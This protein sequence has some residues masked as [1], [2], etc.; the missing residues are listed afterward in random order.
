MSPSLKDLTAKEVA[1]NKRREQRLQTSI[2]QLDAQLNTW[3]KNWAS[4]RVFVK[5]WWPVAVA[6]FGIVMGLIY[7]GMWWVNNVQSKADVEKVEQRL[8]KR[9][10][11]LVRVRK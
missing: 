2:S 1:E 8:N 6:I 9:I 3:N 10:D 11:S 4:L 7:F 5:R